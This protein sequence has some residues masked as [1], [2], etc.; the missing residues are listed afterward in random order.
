[1]CSAAVLDCVRINPFLGINLF[2]GVLSIIISI[3]DFNQR[4]ISYYIKLHFIIAKFI[5]NIIFVVSGHVF[6]VIKLKSAISNEFV[7][8]IHWTYICKITSI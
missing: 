7:H 1:M 3:L 8:D 6:M 4:T 2:C 5:Q